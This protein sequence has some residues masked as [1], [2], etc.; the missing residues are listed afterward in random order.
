MFVFSV[1]RL[2]SRRCHNISTM[3]PLAP[4]SNTTNEPYHNYFGNNINDY[5]LKSSIFFKVDVLLTSGRS[6]YEKYHKS[7]SFLAG[8]FEGV[9]DYRETAGEHGEDGDEGV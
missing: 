9:S 2:V 6:R 3:Y 1:Y 4:A 7:K 8:N 5:E